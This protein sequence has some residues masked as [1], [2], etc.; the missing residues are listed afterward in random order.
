MINDHKKRVLP[1]R[2][3][4]AAVAPPKPLHALPTFNYLEI[5]PTFN[6]I[7]SVM[8]T[9]AEHQ[10]IQDIPS[11]MKELTNIFTTHINHF[12]SK[13]TYFQAAIFL[14]FDS[15]SK[16]QMTDPKQLLLHT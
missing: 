10:A 16:T 5:Y 6:H 3:S 7:F 9:K 15:A 1:K 8:Y 12:K 2:I 13:N 11:I 4:A 14:P